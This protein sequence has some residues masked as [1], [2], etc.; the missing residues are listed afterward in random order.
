[1]TDDFTVSKYMKILLDS[2]FPQFHILSAE[3][4]LK[5]LDERGI[6]RTLE[7]LEYYD[8]I[9]IC[10][11]ALRLHGSLVND[12]FKK[13]TDS[14]SINGIHEYYENG[15]VEFPE[16]DDFKPWN[17]WKDEN[18]DNLCMYYHPFQSFGFE[19][20]TSDLK[21]CIS[22]KQANKITD[23]D[24]LLTRIKKRTREKIDLA[25]KAIKDAW[26]PRI[27]FLMLLEESYA[28]QVR[29]EFTDG[30]P[31]NDSFDRWKEWKLNKFVPENILKHTNL[32]VGQIKLLH[33]HLATE[34]L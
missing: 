1:M 19:R 25:R 5:Y 15:Q 16:D 22:P 12:H 34:G 27:G 2:D 11:P 31:P 7:D 20:V 6:K 23:A 33:N 18:N 30:I 10:K 32:D 29:Q 17:D 24:D 28:I 26:I 13:C 3:K 9:G 4:L 8:E 14:F 21:V